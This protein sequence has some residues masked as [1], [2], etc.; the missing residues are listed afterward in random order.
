MQSKQRGQ[1]MPAIQRIQQNNDPVIQ[2]LYWLKNNSQSV[3]ARR[4]AGKAILSFELGE[5]YAEKAVSFHEL[6]EGQAEEYNK[7]QKQRRFA[8]QES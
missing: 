6:K 3:K 2:E 7:Q 1:S 4:Q 5:T 8:G